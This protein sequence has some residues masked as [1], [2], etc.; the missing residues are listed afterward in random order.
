MKFSRKLVSRIPFIAL[1]LLAIACGNANADLSDLEIG[2]VDGSSFTASIESVSPDGTVTGKQ[3]PDGLNI[4]DIVS[5][6]TARTVKDSGAAKTRVVTVAGGKIFVTNPTVS[7]ELV[8]FN[9]KSGLRSL[10][11]QSVRAIIWKE[12]PGLTKSMAAPSKEDDR[13]HALGKSGE[14]KVEGILEKVDSESLY[15]NYKGK[16]RPIGLG[17][18]TAVITADLGITN[19]P[20]SQA[21]V[22]LTDGSKLIGVISQ[23]S[24][25]NLTLKMAGTDAVEIESDLIASVSIVSD[26]LTYLSDLKPVLVEEK[27][28]FAIQRDWQRDQSVERNRLSIRSADGEKITTYSRGI[29]AQSYS[30]LTFEN[31][32]DFDRFSAV[33]GIDAET[34]GAGDCRMVVLGDGIELWSKRIKADEGPAK[35]DVE[36]SGMKQVSL[37][38]YP[39]EQFDLGDHANWCNARFLK[40]K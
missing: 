3:I 14:Q 21:T 16:S 7:D 6:S 27:S 35:I 10:P 38:V 28:V 4:G 15:I 18:V 24:N 26:R 1:A 39:G 37:V 5:I 36:I 31:T 11:L 13:V 22:Q 32:R 12:S 20:G 9:S 8:Q 40:T 33:V 23:Y 25:G 29:G 17:K 30:N 34:M 19:P 2:L